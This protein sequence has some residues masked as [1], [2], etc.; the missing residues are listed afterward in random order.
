M[1]KKLLI[2]VAIVM[3]LALMVGCTAVPVAA[4]A[5]GGSETL[6]FSS[7]LF[8]PPREQEF[9]I[10]EV[11][12][13]FEEENGVTV[14]FQ[15]LDDDTLLERAM[16]QQDTDHVTTDIVAAHNSRMAEWIDAGYVQ[17]LTPLVESWDDR[18]FSEAFVENTNMD[19][20]QYFL[21]VG[22][23][24]YLL[25]AN[26]QAVDYLPEGMDINAMTWDQYAEWANAIA[27]G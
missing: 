19:G 14:N 25:L 18:T 16:V 21:P 5:E 13:P 11:I 8:S 9:F 7:R 1:N 24:V 27:A 6:V 23:D 10:N 26:N 2:V 3:G 15:I 17:D 22:A 20:K 4:P 12:K